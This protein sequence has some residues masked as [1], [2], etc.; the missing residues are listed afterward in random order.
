MNRGKIFELFKRLFLIIKTN[1]WYI[2][3]FIIYFFISFLSL[4]SR[5]EEDTAIVILFLY[6]ISLVIAFWAGEIILKFIEGARPVETKKEKEYLVLI[7]EE[8]YEN[9]KYLHPALPKI[10]LHII[11]SLTVNAMAIGKST[12]AITQGVIDTLSSEELKG[13]MAHEISHIYYGD[14]K[15]TIINIIGNG[16]FSI[17]IIL[18]KITLKL[19]EYFTMLLPDR[20]MKTIVNILQVMF[21]LWISVILLTGTI[22]FSSHKRSCEFKADEFAF[23]C[24]YGAQL[25]E[26]LYIIKKMNLGQ[27]VSIISRMQASHPRISKRIAILEEITDKEI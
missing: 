20:A 22:I 25:I 10:K 6:F 15:A 3:W 14:T 11:D 26:A 8:V 24:G 1:I 12:L 7:F 5:F 19:F 16:I 17:Q 4:K 27:K 23:K 21:E 18:L 2:I 13:I 9:I